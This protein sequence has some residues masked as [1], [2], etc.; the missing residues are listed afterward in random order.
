MGRVLRSEEDCAECLCRVCAHN[1]A[2]DSYNP[3]LEYGCKD[4][5][6][7]EC[8]RIGETE[9]IDLDTDCP[10]ESYLPDVSEL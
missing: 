5:I 10:K 8:C 7:S 4:C 3:E 6:A 1:V 2:N 9:I